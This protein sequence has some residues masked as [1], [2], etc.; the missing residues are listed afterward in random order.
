M[1]WREW[2]VSGRRTIVD[3]DAEV[4]SFTSS[5]CGTWT[6]DLSPRVTPGTPFGDGMYLVGTEVATGRYRAASPSDACEWAVFPDVSGALGVDAWREE[7]RF[8]EGR[9]LTIADITERDLAFFSSG[10]GEWTADPSPVGTPVTSFGA[11][12][13]V[14]GS[15][16]E[17]GRYF[18]ESPSD[19]CTWALVARSFQVGG[20]R[21]RGTRPIVDIEP[22]HLGFASTGCGTWSADPAA[23]PRLGTTFG[24]G[25]F[26][27]GVEIE[28]GRY[29]AA[30]PSEECVWQRLH[31]FAG[32]IEGGPHDDHVAGHGVS[33]IPYVD[34]APTDAGF[35]STGCGTWSADLS[36]RISPGEPFGAGTYFVGSEIAPGRYRAT[37]PTPECRWWRVSG[38]RGEYY[39]TGDVLFPK[40]LTDGGYAR[41]GTAIAEIAA[42]D[43]A[44]F[45]HGCGEWGTDFTPRMTPGEPFGAGTFLVGVEIQPGRYRAWPAD[46]TCHWRRLSGFSGFFS[47]QLG[48]ESVD[49]RMGPAFVDIAPTDVGFSSRGCRAWSPYEAEFDWL[50]TSFDDGTY[51]VGASVAPGRYRA[52]APRWCLWER[53]G[54]FGGTE[55]DVLALVVSMVIPE[56]PAG[57]TIVDIKAT[58][59]GFRTSRCGT[60]SMDLSPVIRPGQSF[61][62]GWY[63]IGSEIAPGRYHATTPDSCRWKRL[64]G[65]GGADEDVI[66]SSNVDTRAIVDI[67]ASDTGLVSWGCGG[68]ATTAT[69]TAER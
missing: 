69:A 1:G 54:G 29:H 28:P 21:E 56:Q 66:E 30:N 32:E 62:D 24:D 61:G 31:R 33:F 11:G 57:A 55:E 14:V 41:A 17:P 12:T 10:C 34:I 20:T 67:V 43:T 7:G 15:D 13:F 18:A 59:A 35:V 37:E 65:F 2:T 25:A 3:I 36:P 60:W 45:S 23:R 48:Y 53:L 4:T 9:W 52:D 26:I 22:S 64:S 6:T 58:D 5:G 8:A 16:V 40:D 38:F 49:P 39:D 51:V 47:S 42:T 19:Q 50:R 63:I 68:W 44:F 46:A 27:V